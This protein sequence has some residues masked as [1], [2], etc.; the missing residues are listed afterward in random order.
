MRGIDVGNVLPA[1]QALYLAH[2]ELALGKAGIAAVG[3]AFVADG[4][5]AVWV[6][7]QAEQLAVVLFI[8][9]IVVYNCSMRPI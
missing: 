7:G 6:D 4:G 9:L 5:E 1:E 8:L 3:L 2:F